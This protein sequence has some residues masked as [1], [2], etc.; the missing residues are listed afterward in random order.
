MQVANS[1]YLQQRINIGMSVDADQDFV[2]VP[3]QSLPPSAV[4]SV[5]E[6]RLSQSPGSSQNGGL[7]HVDG[8]L[9]ENGQ[10]VLRI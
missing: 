9:S 8:Q 10:I 3:N 4:A 6:K 1:I 2:S 5:T 7:V